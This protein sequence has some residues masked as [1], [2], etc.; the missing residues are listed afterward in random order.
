MVGQV[1]Q[2]M[3]SKR[4]PKLAVELSFKPNCD[5]HVKEGFKGFNEAGARYSPNHAI[6]NA[7]ICILFNRNRDADHKRNIFVL[8]AQ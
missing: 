3:M 5:F 4:E 7:Q 2:Q 6:I 8:L 1:L